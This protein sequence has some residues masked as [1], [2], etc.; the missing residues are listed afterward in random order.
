VTVLEV[1]IPS[2]VC[3]ILDTHV[4][5]EDAVIG[6]DC[7]DMPIWDSLACVPI[8]LTLTACQPVSLPLAPMREEA[9]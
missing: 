9:P 3:H 6:H 4:L 7:P 2:H 8:S 5:G 1:E